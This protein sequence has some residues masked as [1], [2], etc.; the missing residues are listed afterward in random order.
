MSDIIKNLVIWTVIAVVLM[1]LFSGI[2]GRN[3]ASDE[4]NYSEFMQQVQ[5]GQVEEVTISGIEITGTLKSGQS[6]ITYSPE[7]DNSALVGELLNSK[8]K[9][10]GQA[11]ENRCMDIHYET[12]AGW[13]RRWS[14][15]HVIW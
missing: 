4:Y 1:S 9:I 14:W 2:S 10:S 11:P 12:N 3:N 7:T 13:S 8:V 5:T 6:F 15:S